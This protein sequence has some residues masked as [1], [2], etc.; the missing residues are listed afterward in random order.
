MKIERIDHV[1]FTV[2]NIA[3]CCAFYSGILG[4]KVITFEKGR[5]ALTFGKQKINLHEVG[6]EF[7]PKAHHAAS[8]TADLCFITKSTIHEIAKHLE[9]HG[10]EIVAGPSIETGALGKMESIYFRDPDSNLIEVATYEV[11]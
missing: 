6:N 10:V 1:V 2:K 8:G 7:E 11:D 3:A 5:K 4:M 9:K